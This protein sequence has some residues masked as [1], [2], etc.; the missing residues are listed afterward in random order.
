M[1]V[2]PVGIGQAVDADPAGPAVA[3]PHGTLG[4]RNAESTPTK[5]KDAIRHVP[6]T[7]HLLKLQHRHRALQ[8]GIQG[9][10]LARGNPKASVPGS[11]GVWDGGRMAAVRRARLRCFRGSGVFHFRPPVHDEGRRQAR[12]GGHLFAEAEQALDHNKPTL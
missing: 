4:A 10:A 3:I 9:A 7:N 5:A 1:G 2:A 11:H 6:A 8:E 12:P